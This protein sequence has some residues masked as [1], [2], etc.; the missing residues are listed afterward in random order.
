MKLKKSVF[1]FF[2][3]NSFLHLHFFL[4]IQSNQNLN[5]QVLT[6]IIKGTLPNTLPISTVATTCF[7]HDDTTYNTANEDDDD[8]EEEEQQAVNY[9]RS[10]SWTSISRVVDPRATWLQEWN[11]VVL[12]VCAAGLF[13]DPLFFYALSIHVCSESWKMNTILC[14]LN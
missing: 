12:L 4:S 14:L 8:E 1:F 10:K 2:N 13:V 11:R 7:T 3:F 5:L 9:R 6:S